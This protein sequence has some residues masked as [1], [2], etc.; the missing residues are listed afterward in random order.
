MQ[1]SYRLSVGELDEKFLLSVKAL[2]GQPD[3]QI[4]IYR[5]DTPSVFASY[6][7]RVA[8]RGSRCTGSESGGSPP[9]APSGEEEAPR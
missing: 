7:I 3:E 9:L 5:H 2:F 6:L 1:T 8:P 4:E